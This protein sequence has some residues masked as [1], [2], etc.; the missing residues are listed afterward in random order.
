M[1]KTF[2]FFQV[3][4]DLNRLHIRAGKIKLNPDPAIGCMP[5]NCMNI[6]KLY[7]VEVDVDHDVLVDDEIMHGGIEAQ[8]AAIEIQGADTVGALVA[9]HGSD[10]YDEFSRLVAYG[11]STV[12]TF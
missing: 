12:L 3:V 6:M 5:Y 8:A 11:L 7:A 2:D 1:Q 4:Q 10:I 9:A